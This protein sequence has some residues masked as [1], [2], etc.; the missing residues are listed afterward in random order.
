MPIITQTKALMPRASAAAPDPPMGIYRH[1][2]G[3]WVFEPMSRRRVRDD[4]W[5]MAID[6]AMRRQREPVTRLYDAA[7][8]LLFAAQTLNAAA[9]VR[10]ATP[11]VAAT[12]G[13]FEATLD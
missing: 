9:G 13:C 11:A 8:E 5:G 10:D 6:T 3:S 2:R 1:S 12:V 7:C 4:P